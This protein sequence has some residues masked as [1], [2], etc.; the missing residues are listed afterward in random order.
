[1][2]WNTA[3]KLCSYALTKWKKLCRNWK[4]AWVG[5]AFI[6]GKYSKGELWEVNEEYWEYR[7][8]RKARIASWIWKAVWYTALIARNWE[9][10]CKG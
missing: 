2:L 6:L 7:N 8:S 4:R 10:I 9:V 3:Q 5:H 1:M